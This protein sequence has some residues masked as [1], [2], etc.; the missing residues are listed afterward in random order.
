MSVTTNWACRKNPPG[1]LEKS[2][3]DQDLKLFREV[4]LW[5]KCEVWKVNF[6]L[7]KILK[8]TWELFTLDKKDPHSGFEG[9]ALLRQLVCIGVLDEGEMKL[10]YTLGLKTEGFLERWLQSQVLKLGLV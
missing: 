9:S 1:L 8:A 3:L 4:G 2:C 6:T 10:D 5:N 7:A